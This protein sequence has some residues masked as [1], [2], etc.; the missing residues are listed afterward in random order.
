MYPIF[1]ETADMLGIPIT[2]VFTDGPTWKDSLDQLKQIQE[3]C[4]SV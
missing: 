2:W 1:L 4:G 3:M